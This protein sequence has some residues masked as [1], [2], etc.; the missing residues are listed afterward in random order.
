MIKSFR[1]KQ[2]QALFDGQ[3]SRLAKR[4]PADIKKRAIRKMDQLNAAADLQDLKVPPNNQLEKLQGDLAGYYSIRV[5]K[6]Y[7]IIFK[8]H[9]GHVYNVDIIDYH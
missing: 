6:Q 8:W 4:L 7:R 3:R 1:S 2:E 9:N 5:N